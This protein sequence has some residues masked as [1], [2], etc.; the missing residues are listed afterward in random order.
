MKRRPWTLAR[1]W[2]E[3]APAVCVWQALELL[4]AGKSVVTP[5]REIISKA[6]GI[7]RLPTISAALTTLEAA[8]WIS[9]AHV[10]VTV[11]GKQTATLLRI[12]LHRRERKVFL[13]EHNPVENG[14][15]SKGRERKVFQDFSKEKGRTDAAPLSAGGCAPNC[16]KPEDLAPLD[17]DTNIPRAI[18]AAQRRLAG[19]GAAV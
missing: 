3:N 1:L 17:P 6:A 9:R 5:T 13:T 8:G 7:H 14:K 16:P 10:P 4:A 2:R 11:G 18:L 15:R 12:V 19:Q